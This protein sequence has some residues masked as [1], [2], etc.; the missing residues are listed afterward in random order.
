MSAVS[1]YHSCP[2][3]DCFEVAIG[4]LI[5]LDEDG[6]EVESEDEPALCLACEEAGCDH[7]GGSECACEPDEDLDTDGEEVAR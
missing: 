5:T 6:D 7:T 3:R 1:G 4:G 2:C